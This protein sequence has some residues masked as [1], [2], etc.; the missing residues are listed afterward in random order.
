MIVA[1]FAQKKI[2]TLVL[3]RMDDLSEPSDEELC[4]AGANGI[5]QYQFELLVRDLV[6]RN[7]QIVLEEDSNVE[8]TDDENIAEAIQDQ[9]RVDNLAWYSSWS[10]ARSPY[11]T[12]VIRP[13][14]RCLKCLYY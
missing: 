13:N 6:P 10:L 3:G 8:S 2:Y 12:Y 5:K 1:L 4:P 11:I 14:F 9:Q 7:G